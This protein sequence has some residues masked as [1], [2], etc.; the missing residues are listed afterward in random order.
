MHRSRHLLYILLLPTLNAR[1]R[2][3]QE[4]EDEDLTRQ[5]TAGAMARQ[6]SLGGRQRQRKPRTAPH[7][8]GSGVGAEQSAASEGELTERRL[9]QQEVGVALV[10]AMPLP[11]QCPCPCNTLVDAMCWMWGTR[12]W[13]AVDVGGTT[14]R[15]TR[16][17]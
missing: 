13:S 12:C 1:E 5:S 11:M 4:I 2:V 3:L 10:D 16:G 17:L 6:G 7:E 15:P 9:R 8:D 14:I